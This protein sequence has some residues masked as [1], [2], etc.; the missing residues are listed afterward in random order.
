[1]EEEGEDVP[2]TRSNQ[3][4]PCHDPTEEYEDRTNQTLRPHLVKSADDR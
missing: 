1:M 2:E 3:T 4:N